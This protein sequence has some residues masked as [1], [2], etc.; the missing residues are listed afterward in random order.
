VGSELASTSEATFDALISSSKPVFVYWAEDTLTCTLMT[1]VVE[2]LA[3]EGGDKISFAKLEID[4]NPMADRV[5]R[6]S[7]RSGARVDGRHRG[8]RRDRRST[9]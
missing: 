8:R 9:R 5:R 4:E 7:A 1:P 2:A 6:V 3:H